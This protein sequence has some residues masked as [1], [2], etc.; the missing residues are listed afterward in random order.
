MSRARVV[1]TLVLTTF[2]AVLIAPAA[3]AAYTIGV[4]DGISYSYDPAN[5]AAGARVYDYDGVGVGDPLVVDIPA[6]VV[7]GPDTYAVTAIE[8]SAFD[9]NSLTGV[10]IPNSV[11]TIGNNAFYNNALTSVVIPDSVTT[12]GN[13]AFDSN[14]LTSVT[15]PSSLSTL[16]SSVL[17]GNDLTS[18]TIPNS[19]TTIE[20]GALAGNNLTAVTIPSG[21]TSIGNGAFT[22]NDLTSMTIPDLVTSIGPTA[23]SNNNLTSI[24][25]GNSVATLGEAAFSGNSLTTVTIPY[26]VTTIRGYVFED[27]P[28]TA[29]EFSGNEPTTIGDDPLGSTDG[30]SGPLVTFY[31]RNTGFDSPTWTVGGRTYRS[32]ELAT[33]TFDVSGHGTAPAAADVV[34]GQTVANPGD[35]TEAAYAFDGWFTAASGGTAVVFPYAV[36][37]DVTLYAHWSDIPETMTSPA[38]ASS[39]DSIAVTG[40]GFA[41]GETIEIWL[42]STPVMLASTTAAGDGTLAVTVT[43]PEGTSPG[44]H[45]LEARAASGTASNAISIAG[46]LAATGSGSAPMAGLALAL[47]C[48]GTMLIAASRRRAV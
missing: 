41:P 21:V 5:V 45:H 24:T 44:A 16:S 48:A 11:T 15:L 25:L 8:G 18:V 6:S 12:I 23:F 17:A 38:S 3:S 29:V 14:S 26:S 20:Y 39:G 47:M 32:Q 33:V 34:V 10:T 2:A 7:I 36:T 1:F 43:I 40:A 28:L 46:A 30:A 9:S 35:L 4:I 37:A 22:G 13:S 31:D 42:L 19:V 27:N